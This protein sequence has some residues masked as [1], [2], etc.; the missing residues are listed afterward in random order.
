MMMRW[1]IDCIIWLESCYFPK[2]MYISGSIEKKWLVHQLSVIK[3]FT[4]Q[5]FHET[6]S[7]FSDLTLCSTQLQQSLLSWKL[8]WCHLWC[9]TQVPPWVPLGEVGEDE[10]AYAQH[11]LPDALER[12]QWSWL[13]QLP[14]QCCVQVRKI[15]I[16][17]WVWL[18]SVVIAVMSL[19]I[20]C[21]FHYCMY[22]LLWIYLFIYVANRLL[23]F[24]YL[25]IYSFLCQS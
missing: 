21:M 20:M 4:M 22:Y 13:Y 11:T 23:Y 2:T 17:V 1:L 8:G 10:A 6:I 25:C 18:C 9:G 7:S 3:E 24:I 5:D 19:L 16:Y 14:W 15:L 12:S